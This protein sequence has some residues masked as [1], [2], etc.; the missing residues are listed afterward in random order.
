MNKEEFLKRKSE[1]QLQIDS[2]KRELTFLKDAYIASNQKYPIGSKVCITIPSL[3]WNSE[4]R[5]NIIEPS[6]QRYAFVAGYAIGFGDEVIPIFHAMKADGTMSNIREPYYNYE[7]I[8]LV[9]ES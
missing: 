6:L 9:E 2:W 4:D 8:E 3:H 7:T 1:I 5:K